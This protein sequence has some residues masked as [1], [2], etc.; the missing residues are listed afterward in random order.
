M[1]PK[2][3][4]ELENLICGKKRHIDVNEPREKIIDCINQLVAANFPG[5]FTKGEFIENPDYLIYDLHFSVNNGFNESIRLLDFGD[6][7][8]LIKLTH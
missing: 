6:K 5:C 1:T 2:I 8:K 7:L 3:S 4:S